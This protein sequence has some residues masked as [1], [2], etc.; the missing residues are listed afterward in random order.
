MY[1]CG[2][3]VPS[4]ISGLETNM[5]Q[6]CITFQ[7]SQMNQPWNF[8]PLIQSIPYLHVGLPREV[9]FGKDIRSSQ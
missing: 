8:S 1:I 7:F 5:R 9:V 2:A 3:D 4:S 6:R